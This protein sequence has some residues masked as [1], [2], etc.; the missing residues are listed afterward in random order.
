M[1][2]N[3]MCSKTEQ[4]GCKFSIRF[5]LVNCEVGFSQFNAK[6]FRSKDGLI[7]GNSDKWDCTYYTIGSDVAL[8]D[9]Q[10]EFNR[11]CEA[12]DVHLY[13]SVDKG[14]ICLIDM[15]PLIGSDYSYDD[16]ETEEEVLQLLVDD[17]VSRSEILEEAEAELLNFIAELTK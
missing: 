4:L 8:E 9:A 13:Y 16:K 7:Q 15:E 3:I 5:D 1:S 12:F 11:D 10:K 17:Y 6:W 2:R 14:P